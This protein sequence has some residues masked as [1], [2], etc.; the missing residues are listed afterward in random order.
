[1]TAVDSDCLMTNNTV[2]KFHDQYEIK[3]STLY[4]RGVERTQRS[5]ASWKYYTI[6]EFLTSEHGVILTSF[7]I[8]TEA[9]AEVN[10]FKP[11]NLTPCSIGK[12]AITVILYR[13]FSLEVHE[14]SKSGRLV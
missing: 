6:M 2:K 10:I 3:L 12:N 1:M 9:T 14:D 11:V 5:M 4:E 13:L 7:K 8:L